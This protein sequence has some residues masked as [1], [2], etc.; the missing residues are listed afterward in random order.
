MLH[1][2]FE[3]RKS[4]YYLEQ[5]LLITQW[6]NNIDYKINSTF[7]FLYINSYLIKFLYYMS[8]N[9]YNLFKLIYI[10]IF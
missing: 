5:K 8:L 2:N 3:F 1:R 4:F 9:I 10:Y 6:K 7:I